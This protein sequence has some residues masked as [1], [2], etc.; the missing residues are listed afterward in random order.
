MC[1]KLVFMLFN[2]EYNTVRELNAFITGASGQSRLQLHNCYHVLQ[3]DWDLLYEENMCVCNHSGLLRLQECLML[4]RDFYPDNWNA[5]YH[6]GDVFVLRRFWPVVH[7][8]VLFHTLLISWV[9]WRI[10]RSQRPITPPYTMSMDALQWP[11][12]PSEAKMKRSDNG[13]ESYLGLALETW[14]LIFSYEVKIS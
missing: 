13:K 12:L 10:L 4:K 3:P 8:I 6:L 5:R 11:D 2:G 9:W 7:A 14:D 1:S